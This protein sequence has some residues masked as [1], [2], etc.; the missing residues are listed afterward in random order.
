MSFLLNSKVNTLGITLDQIDALI[1]QEL[2][3]KQHV[4]AV[5]DPLQFDNN[6]PVSYTHLTLPTKRI[7]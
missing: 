1:Q 3:T 6:L 4:F 5:V 7:V 2:D